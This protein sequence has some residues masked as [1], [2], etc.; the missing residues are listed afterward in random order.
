MV[1]FILE[2]SKAILFIIFGITLIIMG[3]TSKR[4]S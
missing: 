3:Q 2:L 1:D 4:K